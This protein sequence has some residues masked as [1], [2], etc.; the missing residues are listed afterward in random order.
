MLLLQKIRNERFA[1]HR[2]RWAHDHPPRAAARLSQVDSQP[3]ASGQTS[4]RHPVPA[5]R[6]VTWPMADERAERAEGSGGMHPR[7]GDRCL[8][9]DVGLGTIWPMRVQIARRFVSGCR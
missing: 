2:V 8:R 6:T 1:H 7:R 4:A 5:R 3:P 9:D